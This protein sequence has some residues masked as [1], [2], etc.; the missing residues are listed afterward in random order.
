MSTFELK[1]IMTPLTVLRLLSTDTVS[2]ENELQTKISQSPVFFQDSPLV[3]DITALKE[4]QNAINMPSLVRLLRKS[5]L[6]PVG[7]KS[8]NDTQ[9]EIASSLQLGIFPEGRLTN[10]QTNNAAGKSAP[11]AWDG[12][13]LFIKQKIRSGQR[14]HAKGRDLIVL[15]S[16][17]HGAEIIA[18]GHIHVYGTLYGRAMAGGR[19]NTSARIF[20]QSLEAELVSVAGHYRINEDLNENLRGQQVQIFLRDEKQLVIEKL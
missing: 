5:G 2:I 17:S 20:C 16:V 1:G 8:S 13:A 14:I 10:K 15:N 19:D 9:K 11:P 18:D 12:S 6:T 7:L 4:K 3:I